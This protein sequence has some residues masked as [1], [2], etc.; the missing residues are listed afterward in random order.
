MNY[1][2]MSYDI[3]A[4]REIFFFNQITPNSFSPVHIATFTKPDNTQIPMQIF[5]FWTKTLLLLQVFTAPSVR[6]QQVH[7]CQWHTFN[8][9]LETEQDM[10]LIPVFS[11]ESWKGDPPD[12]VSVKIWIWKVIIYPFVVR[13]SSTLTKKCS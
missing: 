9:A 7:K 5:G 1:S 3:W 6:S 10:L 11:I 4:T 13:T 12:S 2:V 8:F